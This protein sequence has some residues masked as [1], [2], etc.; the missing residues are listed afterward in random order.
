MSSIKLALLLILSFS[1]AFSTGGRGGG[2]R[3]RGG[4]YHSTSRSYS[5]HKAA[6]RVSGQYRASPRS[7]GRVRSTSHTRI[8]SRHYRPK[9][10]S[11]GSYNSHSAVSGQRDRHGRI[12]RTEHARRQFMK[13]TGYPHGRPGYVIDHITPLSK[14]GVDSPSNMQWQTKE[15]AKA[16]D[17][18][19]RK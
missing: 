13:Q 7:Y 8:S 4:S 15:Q 12:K 18:W 3:S 16:K 19:E 10:S 6:P 5:G 2:R 9:Y 11:G 17:K 1:V 14:G